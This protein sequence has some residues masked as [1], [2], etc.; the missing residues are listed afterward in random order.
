MSRADTGT[1]SPSPTGAVGA[2]LA[3][4][5][6][7]GAGGCTDTRDVDTGAPVFTG[8]PRDDGRALAGNRADLVARRR[9]GNRVGGR[10]YSSMVSRRNLC[11]QRQDLE[12][13]IIVNG[14]E[15]SKKKAKIP[16][17][18]GAFPGT[19]SL[20]LCLNLSMIIRTSPPLDRAR[21]LARLGA[22]AKWNTIGVEVDSEEGARASHW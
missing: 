13:E 19:L 7:L 22:I 10:M 14:K 1:R 6:P 18:C 16:L 12:S 8:T 21:R 5:F 15:S 9:L 17:D 20:F 11:S 2:A 4:G 3:T